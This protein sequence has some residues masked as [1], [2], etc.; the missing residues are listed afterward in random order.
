MTGEVRRA[1][2]SVGSNCEADVHIPAGLAALRASFGSLRVSAAYR[3][4]PWGATGAPYVNLAVTFLTRLEWRP[5]R[6]EL[7]RIERDEDRERGTRGSSRVTLD[8]DLVVL[9]ACEIE[10]DG[11]ILPSPDVLKRGYV[12]GPLAEIWPDW[13]HPRAGRTLAALWREFDRTD[14]VLESVPVPDTR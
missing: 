5:L 3:N 1:G 9:D 11:F 2:V 6:A 14:V 10:E 12:L 4:A 7:T 8:L 13:V